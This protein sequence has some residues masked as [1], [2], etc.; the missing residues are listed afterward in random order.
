M[1]SNVI[2]VASDTSVVAALP[3][4]STIKPAAISIASAAFTDVLLLMDHTEILCAR[5]AQD[6]THRL[7]HLHPQCLRFSCRRC[8]RVRRTTI[9]HVAN[10]Q[11]Q[12]LYQETHH[13]YYQYP[14]QTLTNLAANYIIPVRSI[15]LKSTRNR[16]YTII[17]VGYTCNHAVGA[18]NQSQYLQCQKSLLHLPKAL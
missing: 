4:S 12:M 10:Q 3:A 9:Y 7:N 11:L 14:K 17:N 15:V 8:N 13:H 16:K 6:H 18:V 2:D 1:S 5:H